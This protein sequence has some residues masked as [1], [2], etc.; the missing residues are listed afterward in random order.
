MLTVKN[1]MD[2]IRLVDILNQFEQN[3]VIYE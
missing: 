2:P 1:T 3:I